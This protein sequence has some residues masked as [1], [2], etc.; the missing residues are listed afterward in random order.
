MLTLYG[1]LKVPDVDYVTIY[2]DDEDPHQFYMVPERPSIA[3]DEQG[4]LM[5][6]FILYAR[7]LD[8]IDPKDSEIE[9]GY[10][11]FSTRV[12]VSPADEEKIR[13]YLRS[14]LNGELTGGLVFLMLQIFRA[15]PRLSYPPVYTDGSVEFVTFGD[16]MVR[17]SAGSKEPSLGGENIASFSQVLSQEGAELFRQSIEKNLVPSVIN[18][19]LHFLARIPAVTI[20]IH[21]DRNQFYEE[22]KEHCIVMETYTR[23]GKL[24]YKKTWPEIGSLREFMSK[25]HS[26]TIDFDSGDFREG[27]A[28]GDITQK[29]EDLAFG[30]LQTNI[31]PSFFEQGFSATTEEQSKNK[32]L[33]DFEREVAGM[34]DVTIRRRDVIKKAVNPNAQLAKILTPQE[35]KT[36][37]TYLDLSQTVFTELDLKINANVNFV[38]DPVFAL[39]V[40]VDYNQED[41]LRNVVVAKSKEFLF[42]TGNEVHRFRQIMAKGSDG[43]PK[44]TYRFH[45]ELVY[46]DTGETIRIPATGNLESRER[47]LIISYRRLGFVKVASVLG[48]MPDN[49]KS[50]SVTFRYPSSSLPSATQTFE[51]TKEKPFAVYFTYTGS[52]DTPQPYRYKVVYKLKDGQR[53]EQP[54]QSESAETLTITDP[55]EQ[56]LTTRFLAQGDFSVVQKIIIEARYKDAR[57][58]FQ[59]DFHAELEQ[60]GQTS[61]WSF[62]LRDPN[63]RQFEYD[64]VIILR[65]GGRVAKTGKPGRL[66]TTIPVGSGAVDVLVIEVD[67][68]L[69]DWDKYARAFVFLEYHDPGNGV[70]ENTQFRFD[71]TNK[72]QVKIW[73]VQ[74]RD[75]TKR[76]YR[77]RVRFIGKDAV[78]DHEKDWADKTDRFL[79]IR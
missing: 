16:K 79:V 11:S 33:M 75:E 61:P 47:V 49:I 39:K 73:K 51:L 7:D 25:F 59:T 64:E 43:V 62:N 27:N 57:N 36:H 29:L 8:R 70:H 41:E 38:D 45:S 18:Y 24:V 50:A 52:S 48:T 63:S 35:V 3:R 74:L 69:L 58:D 56:A 15:E 71:Q 46:K 30:I 2:R 28:G 22:L 67:I 44:D 60:N 42:K 13:A 9:Q 37:T 65:D 14:L 40:F 31:L 6:T 10:L 55:F 78:N 20:S 21:G 77:F 53:M 34:I 72:D 5:F 23:D 76:G 26:L 19:E 12:G 32:W 1:S 17:V 68:G 54:E 66:G 4:D